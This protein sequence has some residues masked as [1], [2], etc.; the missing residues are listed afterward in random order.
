MWN[1]RNYLK[2]MYLIRAYYPEY[3]KNIQLSNEKTKTQ[4]YKN[5]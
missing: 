1:E 4:F 2:I 3:I 5:G